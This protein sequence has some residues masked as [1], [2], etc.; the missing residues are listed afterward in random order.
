MHARVHVYVCLC[1]CVCAC[2]HVMYAP[3]LGGMVVKE[4][5]RLSSSSLSQSQQQ[6]SYKQS[7]PSTSLQTSNSSSKSTV[8]KAPKQKGTKR[9]KEQKSNAGTKQNVEKQISSQQNK[10]LKSNNTGPADHLTGHPVAMVGPVTID[11]RG[12]DEETPME[13]DK[14][15]S[16]HDRQVKEQKVLP[17]SPR[18]KESFGNALMKVCNL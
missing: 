10:R 11:N 12:H 4:V 9:Q 3:S 2:I 1:V 17:M 14:S 15:L 5:I 13:E 16:S 7:K 8:I 18:S 6:T